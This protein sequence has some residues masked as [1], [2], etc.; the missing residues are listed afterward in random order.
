TQPEKVRVQVALTDSQPASQLKRFTDHATEIA[1]SPSGKEV[2]FVVRGDIY[3]TSV[4]Y[5]QTKRI[6]NSAQ[7]KRSISFS[8][9][10]RRLVF[11]AEYNQ[12]WS[13]N[14][15]A[16]VQAKEKEPYFF[17]STIIDV[18]PLLANEHDNFQPRYSPDGKEVAFLEDR[19]TLKVLN[20]ETRQT[21]I[22]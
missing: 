19:T 8:P 9:D 21:R 3:V 15:A 16:I 2:A 6:T 12:P 11:A 14:E 4:E 5:G 10:G 17:N 20:L 7:Q 18:H 13:L 1:V 22:I